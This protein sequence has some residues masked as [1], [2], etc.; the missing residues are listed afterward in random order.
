MLLSLHEDDGTLIQCH[1]CRF[2]DSYQVRHIFCTKKLST[3]IHFKEAIVLALSVFRMSID[4]EKE[5]F[6]QLKNHHK[7]I[8]G[9]FVWASLGTMA[10]SPDA[11]R[12]LRQHKEKSEIIEIGVF[13]DSAEL[14][15]SNKEVM[16]NLEDDPEA[17]VKLNGKPIA[18][19]FFIAK[20]SQG[21]LWDLRETVNET[22]GSYAVRS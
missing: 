15:A 6:I 16:G 20:N 19:R 5:S 14:P 17:T 13:L 7:L 9:S 2:P 21:T 12:L 22:P 3:D 18:M 1:L 10:N 4:E 8:D 11:W